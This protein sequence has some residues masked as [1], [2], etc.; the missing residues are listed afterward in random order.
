MKYKVNVWPLLLLSSLIIVINFGCA[1][2]KK[3]TSSKESPGKQIVLRLPPSATNPR[4]SE[5]SFIQLKN[6]AILFVYTHFTNGYSDFSHAYFAGRISTDGGKTWSTKDVVILPNEGKKNIMEPGLLRLQNGNI[7]LF[8]LRKNSD[9]DCIPYVRIS[10]DEAKTWSAPVRCIPDTSYFVVNNDRPVQL[11]DGRI[12]IPVAGNGGV[13]SCYSDDNGKAWH[14]STAASNPDHILLQEPGVVELR[15]GTIMMFIRTD[16]GV[17][18]VSYSRD[19]GQSWSKVEPSNIA[20]PLSPASIKRIPSTGDLLMVWNNNDG[21]I[22]N[23]AGKRTPLNV[24][25]S[26]DEGKTWEHIRTI[27]DNPQGWYCYTAICFTED[28]HVLLSYC[29]GITSKEPGLAATH[30]TRLSLDWIYGQK[31]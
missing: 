20:S 4:N 13:W 21:H 3:I 29:A 12:L 24:A 19:E 16:E 10:K 14:S 27:E 9:H 22:K 15:N 6:G 1:V 25:I 2:K 30:V 31:N 28:H 23:I 26:K 17:Q 7:A 8:Y 11:K 18:Y 5:G